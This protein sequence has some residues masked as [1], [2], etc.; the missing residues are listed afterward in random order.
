[1]MD[2]TIQRDD[3]LDDFDIPTPPG[4]TY[5]TFNEAF[6][7]LN[8]ELFGGDLPDVLITMQRR[9]G[10]RGYFAADRFAHRRGTEIHRRDRSQSGG[11]ARSIRPGDCFNA[12]A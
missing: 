3:N 5:S 11:N 12:G 8:D 4:E 2:R 6:T 7:A 10:A 9:H 1:M